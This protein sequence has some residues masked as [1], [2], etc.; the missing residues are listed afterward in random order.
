M[1]K[2]DRA[3]RVMDKNKH[4]R[5]HHQEIQHPEY[6]KILDTCWEK[7]RQTESKREN[8]QVTFHYSETGII[9]DCLTA[10][11]E[12]RK[13]RHNALKTISHREFCTQP[14]LL[15][16]W[17]GLKDL[18]S[19]L[20]NLEATSGYAFL[21]KES[22]NTCPRRSVQGRG[23]SVEGA[24]DNTTREAQTRKLQEK[25]LEEKWTL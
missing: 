9:S 22:L 25:F 17:K 21:M 2:I 13:Q 24:E 14:N 12:A 7:Q 4:T 5:T 3:N 15:V 20:H 16:K 18:P 8:K 11:L 1:E 19:H 10:F 23:S 6:K